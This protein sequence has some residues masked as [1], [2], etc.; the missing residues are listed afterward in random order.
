M[1]FSDKYEIFQKISEG[2]FGQVYKGKNKL[3]NEFVAVKIEKRTG[4]N[5]L[6]SEAKIYQY[7]G[8]QK[9][10]PQLKWFELNSNNN[11]LVIDYLGESLAELVSKYKSIHINTVLKI[12][13]QIIQRLQ[14]LHSKDMVH[15]DIKP[16]NILLGY[17]DKGTIYLI[18]FTFA[19]R[20]LINR[21]HMKEELTNKLIGSLNF[22]SLNVHK[23]LEPSRRDDIIS[24]I[25][26]LIYLFF[27]KLEWEN[28]SN[29]NSIILLKE[30]ALTADNIPVLF[31]NLLH[32][33]SNLTFAEKPNYDYIISLM[34]GGIS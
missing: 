12:G 34:F 2:S 32:Y 21:R 17:K 19:K 22:V 29:E 6:K 10:F 4:I 20:F 14:L 24:T 5:T 33:C 31:R 15:R 27:G 9:G 28:C 7:I 16:Q 23:R 3:T 11:I 8:K 18:D 30:S 26:V 13:I 1:T 25:Y